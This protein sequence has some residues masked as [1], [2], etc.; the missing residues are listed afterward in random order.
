MVL[1]NIGYQKKS[2]MKEQIENKRTISQ[3]AKIHAMFDALVLPQEK[4]DELVYEITCKRTI[5]TSELTY[6][7][8]QELIKFL[9]NA[10]YKCVR[11]TASE[12]VDTSNDQELIAKLDKKRKGLIRSIFAWFELQGKVV[13]MYYVKGVACKAAGVDDFNKISEGSL[14][15]MYAEFC[16]KQRARE[17]MKNDDRDLCQK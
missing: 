6:T 15:R 5:H 16:R 7:E 2:N 3:N 4:R 14:T 12:K 8:A 10:E 13:D 11:L 1:R 9:Q 17:V